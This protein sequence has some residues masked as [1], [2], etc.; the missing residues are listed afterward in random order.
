MRAEAGGPQRINTAKK[1]ADAK[2]KEEIP[3]PET[4]EPV[5]NV[6]DPKDEE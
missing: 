2:L 3:V 1:H 6:E 4:I 5:Q